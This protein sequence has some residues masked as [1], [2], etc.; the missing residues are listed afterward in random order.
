MMGSGKP[1]DLATI[2]AN[3]P[4]MDIKINVVLGPE[5]VNG[6]DI[7]KTLET[8]QGMN[9]R[10]VNLREPYG[11]PHIGD[12]LAK[13]PAK[14]V[15]QVLGMPSY[16]YRGM[17]VTYWDVHYVEVESV[18]LYANGKVSITYPITKG[19]D[20]SGTVLPQVFFPGGRIHEQWL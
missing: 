11:Q 8:L 20:P 17:S 9:V 12:P 7:F 15:K 4:N 14:Y 3:H 18:N 5:N 2:L 1:P 10:R 19:H 13:S 16:D 6:G